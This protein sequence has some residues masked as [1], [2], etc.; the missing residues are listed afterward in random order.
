MADLVQMPHA[1]IY[2]RQLTVEDGHVGFN[3]GKDVQKFSNQRVV[4][5]RIK[6]IQSKFFSH[7][8]PTAFFIDFRISVQSLLQRFNFPDQGINGIGQ[9][10]DIPVGDLRLMAVSIPATLGICGV[11]RPVGIIIFQPAIGTI[12]DGETENRHIVRVHD[13]VDKSHPHPV[14]DHLRRPAADLFEPG[15]IDFRR[16]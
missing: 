16:A 11:R 14:N 12:V 2:Q 7:H 3:E 15:E 4:H 6:F 5:L 1:Y 8:G 10:G 9:L 13:T